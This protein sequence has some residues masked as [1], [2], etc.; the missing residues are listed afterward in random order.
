M[1]YAKDHKT[2]DMFDPLTH[3]GPKRLKMLAESWSGLFRRELL[4]NLPV[5]VPVHLLS[6]YYERDMGRP[7]K[8]LYAMMGVMILQQMKDLTDDEAVRQFA[9]NTEGTM[10]WISA[11][12]QMLRP[13]FARRH[14]GICVH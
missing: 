10:R 9:F 1:I 6:K 11:A 4:P 5:P 14:C 2:Y 7:T 3:L 13:I 12:I 8:E